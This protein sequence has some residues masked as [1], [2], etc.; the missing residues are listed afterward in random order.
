MDR[1]QLM[2][3]F[4][5]VAEA[6]SFSGAARS[7]G[8]S[9]PSVTRA[10]AAL[11]DRLNV[12]LLN[13]S[14]RSVRV[15]EA[16]QIYQDLVRRI[17]GEIDEADEATAGVNAEPRGRLA[18]TAPVQ[19]G[20]MFVTPAIVEY[21]QRYPEMEVSAL[22][23]DRVVNLLEE[24]LDVAIR[25]GELPD[26]SMR[27]IRVGQV[28]QVVCAS[29]EYL[30]NHPEPQT[31]AELAQHLIVAA[32]SVTPTTDWMFRQGTATTKVRVQPR[33]SVSSIEAALVAVSKGFGITRLMSYQVAPFL[34]TGQLKTILTEYEPPA[35]PIHVLHCEGRYS[36]AKV[37]T[38]IDLVA[39]TLRENA[40]LN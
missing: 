26:S 11:E 13:R 36:S 10:I 38:F 9:P 39:A 24:G 29:P 27:A 19:F 28:R 18:I 14:T 40:A 5:A 25:I 12:K 1:L 16:G 22:F 30:A 2:E 20:Q 17:L 3:V 4:I 33:F 32:T 23:L 7:L 6:E 15:T 8:M 37:R 35:L 34:R 31:P 21:L